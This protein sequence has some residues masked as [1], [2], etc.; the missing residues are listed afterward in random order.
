MNGPEPSPR[1][2]SNEEREI[3]SSA[4]GFRGWRDMVAALSTPIRR[5]TPAPAAAASVRS[6]VGVRSGFVAIRR[7]PW[8]GS[9]HTRLPSAAAIVAACSQVIVPVGDSHILDAVR[10]LA[11]LAMHEHTA[12]S[13]EPISPAQ[14]ALQHDELTAALDRLTAAALPARW[15]ASVVV[16]TESLTEVIDRLV[17]FAVTRAVIDPHPATTESRQLDIALT[18]LMAG[19]DQLIADLVTGRRRLPRYQSVPA[20]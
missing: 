19:Y 6:V 12:D 18:D 15:R 14:V 4:L 16:H 17:T 5:R 10:D 20:T 3:V 1:P 2:I 13:R 7:R 8:T 11:M 9:A